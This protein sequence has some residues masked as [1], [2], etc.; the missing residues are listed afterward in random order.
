MRVTL[1]I[2]AIFVIGCNINYA[3]TIIKDTQSVNYKRKLFQLIDSSVAISVKNRDTVMRI[4]LVELKKYLEKNISK[5][6]EFLSYY[7]GK[8]GVS[9]NSDVREKENLYWKE[10]YDYYSNILDLFP[11]IYER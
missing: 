8:Q 9:G 7:F 3:Q 6:T 5:Q 2:F 10:N 4:K 1:I 11:E